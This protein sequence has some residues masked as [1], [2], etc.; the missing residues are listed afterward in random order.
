MPLIKPMKSAA[1]FQKPLR[2][3]P[4]SMTHL[5]SRSPVFKALTTAELFLPVIF[6]VGVLTFLIQKPTLAREGILGSSAIKDIKFCNRRPN[7]IYPMFG[8]QPKSGGNFTK[9]Y[10]RVLPGDCRTVNTGY[11]GIYLW[12]GTSEGVRNGA[13]FCMR[14]GDAFHVENQGNSY[15]DIQNGTGWNTCTGLGSKYKW[16]RLSRSPEL[17]HIAFHT[18]VYYYKR[19]CTIYFDAGN[20]VRWECGSW[21]RTG[22][23]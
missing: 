6:V 3:F 11:N 2:L 20:S 15:R 13:G 4:V 9:G 21:Q 18:S 10:Y 12:A 16:V 1:F 8:A 17:V 7:T 14:T 22:K 5:L 23:E 19:Q